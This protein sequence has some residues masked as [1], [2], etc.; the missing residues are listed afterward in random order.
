MGSLI[1]WFVYALIGAGSGWIS[2]RAFRVNAELTW[3]K[4]GPIIAVSAVVWPAAAA[5][6]LIVFM[7]T[8]WSK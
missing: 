7:K 4:A 6:W 3:W 2:Y 8:D 1:F 5:W